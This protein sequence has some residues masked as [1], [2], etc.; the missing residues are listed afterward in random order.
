MINN[1]THTCGWPI[2]KSITI[3]QASP[4]PNSLDLLILC[5]RCGEQI[6]FTVNLSGEGHA[7]TIKLIQ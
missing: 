3:A 7:G 6:V 2:P 1:Q 5:P 4:Y